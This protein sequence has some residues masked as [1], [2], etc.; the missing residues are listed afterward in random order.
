VCDLETSI[1][2]SQWLALGRS[3]SEE[4]QLDKVYQKY[5]EMWCL[6]KTGD[7]SRI[8]HVKNEKVL[9]RAKEEINIIQTKKN[10]G[11]ITEWVAVCVGNAF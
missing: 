9:K 11:R 7:I 4:K 5:L 3:A 1:T 2:R 10:E 6:R 8:D